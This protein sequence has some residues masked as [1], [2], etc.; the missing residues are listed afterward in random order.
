MRTFKAKGNTTRRVAGKMNKTE[1]A[2]SKKTRRTENSKAKS[3][4]GPLSLSH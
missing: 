1:E 3:T 2:Y 4:I